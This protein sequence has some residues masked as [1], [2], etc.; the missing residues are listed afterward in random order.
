[1]A[2]DKKIFDIIPPKRLHNLQEEAVPEVLE[3]VVIKE[4]AILE[5]PVRKIIRKD[6]NSSSQQTVEDEFLLRDIP[7]V[8]RKPSRPKFVL[9]K[10]TVFLAV[11]AVILIAG[12]VSA[13][14]FL[15]VVKIEIWLKTDNLNVKQEVE[16]NKETKTID[17][18]NHVLPGRIITE[19]QT[20]SKEFKATGKV[21]KEE[22]AEGIIRI[23]NDYSTASQPL[24]AAT[25]FVSD[26]GKLFRLVEKA[27]VPGQSTEKGKLVPGFID[28][29]VRADA[30]GPDYNI[31]AST[32]SIPGFAGTP[33]YTAFYAKSSLAMA[34]GFKG[35]SLAVSSEDLEN[36]KKSLTAEIKEKINNVFENRALPGLVLA[37]EKNPII[38]I[39]DSSGVK[40]GQATETFSYE[41]KAKGRAILLSEEDLKKI[42]KTYFINELTEDQKFLTDSIKINSLVKEI[43]EALGTAKLALDISGKT[44]KDLEAGF[45]KDQLKGRSVQ[46]VEKSFKE[47]SQISQAKIRIVPSFIKNL[48]QDVRKIELKINFD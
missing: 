15:P 18:P 22:K 26:E 34:G 10:K 39:N 33:R 24:V 42:A 17:A 37:Q 35:E 19:E 32:F 36:A 20:L 45:V 7:A 31:G 2:M 46:E 21:I 29:L 3:K 6:M 43:D 23:F 11:L 14:F 28:V 1:M 40:P 48:P 8:K 27:V 25:R 30:A 38:I 9:K 16:I 47:L 41:V 13:Y 12:T 4:P 5:K 44:Y